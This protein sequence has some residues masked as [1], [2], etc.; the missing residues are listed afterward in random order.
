MCDV[1]LKNVDAVNA[2]RKEGDT[3]AT[4][5]FDK[6]KQISVIGNEINDKIVKLVRPF[7]DS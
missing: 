1:L 5:Y 3:V 2:V 7:L 4:S 6:L